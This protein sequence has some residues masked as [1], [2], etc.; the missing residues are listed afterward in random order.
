MPLTNT[1]HGLY[2]HKGH[3]GWSF[4]GILIFGYNTNGFDQR[5]VMYALRLLCPGWSLVLGN[6]RH[7]LHVISSGTAGLRFCWSSGIMALLFVVLMNTGKGCYL[8]IK[9]LITCLFVFNINPINSCIMLVWISLY[10][11]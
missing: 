8:E 11:N 7:L 9:I 2:L 10:Y 6:Y 1:H 5:Y 4:D 3:N